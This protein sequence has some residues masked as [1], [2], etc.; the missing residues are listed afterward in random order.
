MPKATTSCELGKPADKDNLNAKSNENA[1]IPVGAGAL[2]V[3][4]SEVFQT[5]IETAPLGLPKRTLLARSRKKRASPADAITMLTIQSDRHVIT[6][7]AFILESI[8][9]RE[10]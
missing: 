4:L 9:G 2:T 6:S 3:Q 8:G 1:A 7:C 5:L 10:A